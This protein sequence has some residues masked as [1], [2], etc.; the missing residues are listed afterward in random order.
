MSFALRRTRVREM[1]AW[2]RLIRT[3]GTHRGRSLHRAICRDIGMGFDFD[4]VMLLTIDTQRRMLVP[5]AAWRP[6]LSGSVRA[7]LATLLRTPL[8]AGHDG[9]LSVTAACA[10]RQEQIFVPDAANPVLESGIT[11]R[12]AI[13]RVL[14]TTGYVA[15]PIV[16]D[17]ETL[18]VLVV[19]RMGRPIPKADRATLS[20]VAGLLGLHR[21]RRPGPGEATRSEFYREP[22]DVLDALDDGVLL[23]EHDGTICYTNPAAARRFG[24]AASE[25]VGLS[26]EEVL[27]SAASAEVR[28]ALS[29]SGPAGLR[30]V[31]EDGTRRIALADGRT[32]FV[33]APRRRL[34]PVPDDG[35]LPM[36]VHDL[37]AP[38][39]SILGFA[40]LLQLGRAGVLDDDQRVFVDYIVRNG[41]TLLALIG[42]ILEVRSPGR[43]A[44]E[45]VGDVHSLIARVIECTAGKAMKA[46]IALEVDVSPAAPPVCID[47]LDF[48]EVVQNLVDNA[49]HAAPA[50]ARVVVR[51]MP[52]GDSLCIEVTPAASRP[53][54]VH[55]TQPFELLRHTPEPDRRR[56]APHLGL[57]IIREIAGRNNGEVWA[58][59]APNG[60]LSFKFVLPVYAGPSAECA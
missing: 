54:G 56:H 58:E 18:G 1:D 37:K 55:Q 21:M 12:A 60:G 25:L 59:P 48:H 15:T 50:G 42:R 2:R 36:L 32:A 34:S 39:Q 51:A 13:V 41:E 16:H 27:Q 9:T 57:R 35:A 22:T 19:D 29:P 5:S 6:G 20:D 40:E 23:V 52:C 46:Q 43:P 49:L 8:D 7:A 10:L 44:A 30:G 3:L 33:L 53:G 26:L 4:R 38:L 28:A 31:A 24:M 14:G 17:G 11:Q 45:L 47:P